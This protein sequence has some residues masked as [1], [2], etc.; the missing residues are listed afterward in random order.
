ME[1]ITRRNA[2]KT[3]LATV[4]ASTVAINGSFA[5]VKPKKKGEIRVVYLGGDQLHNGFTQEFSLR[6]T[7]KD[8]GWAFLSTTNAM[9]VTPEL[10]KDTDLLIITR[11]G[12]PVF[13]WETGPIIDHRKSLEVRD[14]GYMSAELEDAIVDN[15]VNRGMGF[16]GLHCTIWTPDSKK[17]IDMMGIKPIMHGP[18]Q[19][20]KMHNFNQE[21]PITKGYSDFEMPLDENF[22]VT[23]INPKAIPLYETT[24]V[25]DKRHDTA[26][27]CIE[28]GKGRIVGLGAGHTPDPWMSDK[29]RELHWRAAH[30]ALKKEIPAFKAPEKA[31][32]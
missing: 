27:W 23:L 18:V 8:T 26:G 1:N 14:D 22:G 29:Y 11:W 12:G 7:F 19:T 2:L 30:W 17:F 5:A 31:W 6:Y 32:F 20:V 4:A 10:L 28:Q 15:V 24:G 21:H 3:G 25:T 9:N 16:M 13:A